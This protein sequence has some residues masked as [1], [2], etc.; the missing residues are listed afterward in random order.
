[1][2]HSKEHTLIVLRGVVRVTKG[3]AKFFLIFRNALLIHVLMARFLDSDLKRLLEATAVC[4]P[5]KMRAV[6]SIDNVVNRMIQIIY[7]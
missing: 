5:K 7:Y 6:I 3:V 2:F 4:I 1:M